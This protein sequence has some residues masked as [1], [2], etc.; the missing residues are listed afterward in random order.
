LPAA[1]HE[2]VERNAGGRAGVPAK[3]LVKTSL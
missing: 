3:K 1:W 2:D